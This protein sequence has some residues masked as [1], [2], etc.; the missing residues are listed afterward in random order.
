MIISIF[1][2]IKILRYITLKS[3]FIFAI[4]NFIHLS[5]FI[6]IFYLQVMINSRVTLNFIHEFIIRQLFLKI[7]LYSL[8]QIIFIDDKMLSHANHQ[9]ILDYH[10]IN[11]SQRDIFLVTFIDNHFIILG[12]SWLEYINSHINWRF[13]IIEFFLL[14]L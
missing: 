1:M 3:M 13:K 11:I 12:I 4:S 10:I 7:I 5:I 14:S 6:L 2:N 9:V 8:I